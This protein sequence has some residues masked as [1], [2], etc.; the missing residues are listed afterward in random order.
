MITI[1]FA[2]LDFIMA[3]NKIDFLISIL[4]KFFGT[5]NLNGLKPFFLNFNKLAILKIIY[6]VKEKKVWANDFLT[7]LRV[8]NSTN[9]DLLIF[10]PNK[11]P[12]EKY[13]KNIYFLKTKTFEKFCNFSD[14]VTIILN[15]LC[16]KKKI[17]DL[18]NFS[19]LNL[20]DC[21]YKK[22]LRKYSAENPSLMDMTWSNT[23]VPP[24]LP[25]SLNRNSTP[26]KCSKMFNVWLSIP[27]MQIPFCK[28]FLFLSI[29]FHFYKFSSITQLTY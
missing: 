28:F 10:W 15:E 29:G 23:V 25:P 11:S 9:S 8:E 5:T 7:S 3:N 19:N 24:H 21:F 18:Q 17:E 6:A 1:F 13:F 20:A 27:F 2:L 22:Y 14:G 16:S 4:T 26:K 12:A